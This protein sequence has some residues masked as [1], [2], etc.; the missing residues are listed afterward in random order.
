MAAW[1]TV[2]ILNDSL[3]NQKLTMAFC[4]SMYE[5]IEVLQAPGARFTSLLGS[6]L[7]QTCS[8]TETSLIIEILYVH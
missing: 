3:K 7:C 1:S 4:H 8:A 5:A 2:L 6:R